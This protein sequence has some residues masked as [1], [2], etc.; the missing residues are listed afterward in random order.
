MN[1]KTRPRFTAAVAN[2]LFV[3]PGLLFVLL[4]LVFPIFYN[5]WIS[6]Q[7]VTLMNLRGDHRFVERRKVGVGLLKV[8]PG[9]GDLVARPTPSVPR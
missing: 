9:A 7:D 2:Y 1:I 5:V 6:F 3:L 8:G 4:F